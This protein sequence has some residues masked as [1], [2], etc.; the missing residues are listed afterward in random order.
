M[1][2]LKRLQLTERIF[3]V[4]CNVLRRCRNFDNCAFEALAR[5]MDA[6]RAR[7]RFLLAGYTF[8]PNHWHVLNVPS[9]GHSI[10]RAINA[11]KVAAARGNNR[12]RETSGSLWHLR[13]FERIM[14]TVRE[15]HETIEYMHLNPVK[16][17]LV[18]HPGEWAWSSIHCFGGPGPIRLQVDDLNLP[19]DEKTYL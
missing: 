18:R 12:H 11:V 16:A 13:Y 9:R 19:L 10:D 6:V 8:M 2:R 17:G 1:S 14:R 3:F 7:R 4:T 5:A 15:F